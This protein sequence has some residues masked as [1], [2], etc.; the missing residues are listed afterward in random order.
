MRSPRSTRRAARRPRRARRSRRRA[1]SP[2]PTSERSPGRA[3]SR[4]GRACRRGLDCERGACSSCLQPPRSLGWAAW[5][6]AAGV[7]PSNGARSPWRRTRDPYAILVSEVMA[8]QT[9][10]D[11][12]VPRWERWL[13]RW[14]TVEALAAASRRRRDPRVAGARLQPPR[15]QPAPRGAAGRGAR[16]AGRSDRAA[17]RRALHRRCRRVLRA[18]PRRAAGRRERAARRRSAPATR[19]RPRPRRR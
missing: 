14:P 13:E 19:S 8:Q 12:V 1:L 3:R 9:Q 4:R 5:R 2:G 16:L 18:R 10:V 7:V 17:G 15:A 6:R 11:R